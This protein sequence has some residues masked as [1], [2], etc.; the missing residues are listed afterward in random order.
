MC[1]CRLQCQLEQRERLCEERERKV[2]EV[3]RER[4]Q[5]LEHSREELHSLQMTLQSMTSDLQL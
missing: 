5:Q 4:G 2:E 3:C 1:H